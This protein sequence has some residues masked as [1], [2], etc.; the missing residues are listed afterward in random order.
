MRT[1]FPGVRCH[2]CSLPFF[3]FFLSNLTEKM[4]VTQLRPILCDPWTIAHQPIVHGI[5]QARILESAAIPYSRRSSQ[6]RKWTC[7]SCIAGKFFTVWA[8]MKSSVWRKVYQFNQ[9]GH[10]TRYSFVSQVG[11]AE[12]VEVLETYSPRVLSFLCRS[13][14]LLLPS[15]YLNLM[16]SLIPY[17]WNED[18]ISLKRFE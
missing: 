14:L 18:N 8:T 1:G 12:K 5:P 17:L 16:N 7:I 3:F 15:L 9:E 11:R 4:L 10:T 13:A 2:L 6:P